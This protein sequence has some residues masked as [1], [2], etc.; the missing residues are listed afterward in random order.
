MAK[1]RFKE[2]NMSS[3]I[4]NHKT[5]AWSNVSSSKKASKVNIPDDIQVRNA[6]EYVDSNEK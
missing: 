4:E 6:K 1:N 2:K 3:Q 5:A